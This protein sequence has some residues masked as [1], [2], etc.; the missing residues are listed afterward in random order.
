MNHVDVVLVIHIIVFEVYSIWIV[1]NSIDMD[2]LAIL[3]VI[4]DE[5]VVKGIPIRVG[6]SIIGRW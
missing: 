2:L 6:Y 3:A 4:S 1:P 5:G